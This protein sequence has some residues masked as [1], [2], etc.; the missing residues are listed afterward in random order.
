MVE[1]AT[2]PMWLSSRVRISSTAPNWIAIC[3]TNRLVQR[4]VSPSRILSGG[5]DEYAK[6]RDRAEKFCK[7]FTSDGSGSWVK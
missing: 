1:G 6:G 4:L 7:T 3:L 5:S 2:L